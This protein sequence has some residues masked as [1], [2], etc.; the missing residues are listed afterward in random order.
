MD[1]TMPLGRSPIVK[2]SVVINGH[3]TSV[4]IE[5]EFWQELKA[6]ATARKIA[7]G[8]LIDEIDIARTTGNLSSA[9]RLYVLNSVILASR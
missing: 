3:K 5:Q 2:R 9:L 6:M 7:M 4:S 1:R 8:K